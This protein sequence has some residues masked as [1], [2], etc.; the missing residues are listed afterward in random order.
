MSGLGVVRALWLRHGG[1]RRIITISQHSGFSV[2]NQVRI[3]AGDSDGRQKLARYMVR[4]LFSLDK[5]ECLAPTAEGPFLRPLRFTSP[6]PLPARFLRQGG[7]PAPLEMDTTLLKVAS[8][9]VSL[10]CSLGWRY[11]R[12][13]TTRA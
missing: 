8:R 9:S 3:E 13:S 11:T 10:R 7:N 6:P 2:G 1:R 4:A 12:S 5:T